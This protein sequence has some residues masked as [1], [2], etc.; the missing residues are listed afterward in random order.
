MIHQIG[1]GMYVSGPL[2]DRKKERQLGS[3][4]TLPYT[5]GDPTRSGELGRMFDI[6]ASPSPASSRRSS[7]PLPRPSP[8]SGPL[9]QLAH[10]LGLLVGP[11]PSPAHV[12][13]ESKGSSRRG[14]TVA[15]GRVRLGVSFVWY[16]LVAVAAAAALGAGV[17]CL[18]SWRMWEVLAAAGGAVAAV[19]SLHV[20]RTGAEAESFLRRFPDTVFDQG[21]MP[22]GDL[23]KI[24]GVSC[25]AA[26]SSS[27]RPSSCCF[28]TSATRAH[29]RPRIAS[30][31]SSHWKFIA[32]I[33]FLKKK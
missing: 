2:P 23:I 27:N 14:A 25:C 13:S 4:T 9:S 7:G 22:I 15:R 3:A 5:G 24:T 29:R 11:S 16:V 28:L 21:D 17:Y 6:S 31:S 12:G 8:A 19:A 32:C 30:L 18:V 10:P 33:P 26:L 1:S 20:C